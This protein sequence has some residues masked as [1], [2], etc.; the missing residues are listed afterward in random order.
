MI[1]AA[2]ELS[3]ECFSAVIVFFISR[4]CAWFFFMVFIPLLN[5]L[6]CPYIVFLM[7]FS[8]LSVLSFISLSF[9]M[10]IILDSLSGNTSVSISLGLV[11]GVSLGS[12]GGVRFT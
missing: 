3:I 6:F 1:E 4:I 5:V 7:S 11:I 8:C 2:V 12:S 9:Y 10:M